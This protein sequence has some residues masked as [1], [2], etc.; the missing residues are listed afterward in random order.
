LDEQQQR[1]FAWN[2]LVFDRSG[3][4]AEQLRQRYL[5][6]F[7][8]AV[9]VPLDAGLAQRLTT[10]PDTIP[11]V[12]VLISRIG[13]LNQ[14][15]SVFGCRRTLDQESQPDYKL[16]FE[17]GWQKPASTEHVT[18]LQQTYEAYLRWASGSPEFLQREQEAHANRLRGWFALKQF[19]PQQILLWTNQRYASVTVQEYWEEFAAD[20]KKALQVDGAYTPAALQQSLIPFLQRAREAVPDMA[21]LLKE[22]QNDYREQ[23]FTQWRRFLDEFPRGEALPRDA[24]RRLALKLLD[25]Q[26]PYHRILDT[27]YANLKPLLPVEPGSNPTSPGTDSK[28]AQ[29][30]TNLWSR[31]WRMVSQWWSKEAPQA[32]QETVSPLIEPT[33]P[34]WVLI[35]QR[36]L[37]SESRK[38]YLEAMQQTRELLTTGAARSG[39]LSRRQALRKVSPSHP[40]SV[41]HYPAIP[42]QREPRRRRRRATVLAPARTAGAVRLEG[43]ARAHERI[44]AKKL[45]GK[46]CRPCE[47]ATGDRESRFPL[48][49]ARQDP[50]VCQSV[51][52]AFPGQ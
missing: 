34:G 33:P 28:L 47:E 23:Y 16:M 30:P 15:L 41:E 39:W 43:D 35:L 48:R 2:K 26:S 13:L 31:I 9:L 25:E 24:R 27:T 42:R 12:F 8:D 19:A 45:G 44:P 5:T 6:R 52:Q 20:G 36:Y 14:C 3:K 29:Q 17:V 4:L 40:A 46:D 49:A 22:F 10:G 51:R 32:V 50:G 7:T 18:S 11:T 37:A 1:R 38:T 21:P